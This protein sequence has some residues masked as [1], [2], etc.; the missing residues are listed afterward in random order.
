MRRCSPPSAP[1]PASAWFS[2]QSAALY[3]PALLLSPLTLALRPSVREPPT[4]TYL[5]AVCTRLLH[6]LD[7]G[8]DRRVR[9]VLT[10]LSGL[11]RLPLQARFHTSVVRTGLLARLLACVTASPRPS[12]WTAD[13]VSSCSALLSSWGD[14]IWTPPEYR[15][16]AAQLGGGRHDHER[17]GHEGS[18]HDSGP[19][20][21]SMVVTR[22][23]AV[24]PLRANGGVVVT[25]HDGDVFALDPETKAALREA[26][27]KTAAHVAEHTA[28]G[29]D[30]AFE[31]KRERKLL[32]HL[33]DEYMGGGGKGGSGVATG[34]GGDASSAGAVPKPAS[35]EERG[36][37]AGGA[38]PGPHDITT[39]DGALAA[40]QAAMR[41]DEVAMQ[42]ALK[43]SKAAD[44]AEQPS[45][46]PAAAAAAAAAAAPASAS[47]SPPQASP[48]PPAKVSTRRKSSGSTASPK[49]KAS[50]S[51]ASSPRP[52]PSSSP[53]PRSDSFSELQPHLASPELRAD[54]FV[55]KERAGDLLE[56]CTGTGSNSSSPSDGPAAKR[57]G[58]GGSPPE[59]VVSLALR[60]ASSLP[61]AMA[62]S[63]G[64]ASATPASLRAADEEESGDGEEGLRRA[65]AVEA[66]ELCDE[67]KAALSAFTAR[68]PA[69]DACVA[70]NAALAAAREA[71]V[72]RPGGGEATTAAEGAAGAAKS[73]RR[74]GAPSMGAQLAAMVESAREDM[75]QSEIHSDAG[76]GGE[77]SPAPPAGDAEDDDAPPAPDAADDADEED[78]AAAATESP[79]AGG[80]SEARSAVSGGRNIGALLV[81]AA[82]GGH[83][84]AV[85]R[86]LKGATAES[87]SATNRRGQ[88][89][90]A[91]SRLGGHTAV[92]EL[93]LAAGAPE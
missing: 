75:A 31:R 38:Q 83:V 34:G 66:A 2:P 92:V 11:M 60:C 36:G 73:S 4:S 47:A 16:A 74:G 8:S 53:L 32:Q 79:T 76:A 63:A 91:V 50:G 78:A 51:A 84:N 49:P 80:E 28:R 65:I 27:A 67:L 71:A 22:N 41:G 26:E 23:G 1:S 44:I 7:S 3:V 62:L 68:W 87:L 42:E 6:H 18:S 64:A 82:A 30:F 19:G 17:S 72:A 25:G 86:L 45:P 56:A 88:T 33:P 89:A 24:V 85:K 69:C 48:S 37:G 43:N 55:A 5:D 81:A 46:P 40:I 21:P 29:V 13:T 59:K 90:L 77:P 12:G 10:S 14:R 70:I 58:G 93:L 20:T 52:S 61:R 9:S 15:A 39:P 54:V 57:G 35:S